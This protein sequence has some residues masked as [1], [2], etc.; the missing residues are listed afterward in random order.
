MSAIVAMDKDGLIGDGSG[1][2]AWRCKP[3][4]QYFKSMT[5]GQLLVMGY[6]T[7]KGL[8]EQWPTKTVLPNRDVIVLMSV[9]HINVQQ[10]TTF[11]NVQQLYT[12]LLLMLNDHDRVPGGRLFVLPLLD[13]PSDEL[14]SCL[15]RDIQVLAK[16]NQEIFVAGGAR[17]YSLFSSYIS[18]WCVTIIDHQNKPEI[19]VYLDKGLVQDL[20][21]RIASNAV[22]TSLIQT[23]PDNNTVCAMYVI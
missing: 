10:S 13:D 9:R 4:M 17:T 16:P 6:N 18:R 1:K 5:D 22:R 14:I 2:L 3:D 12:E 20:K 11:S 23:D 19:P 21:R 7:Y 8:V 15:V